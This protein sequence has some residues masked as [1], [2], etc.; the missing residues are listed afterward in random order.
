M[1]AS[2]IIQRVLRLISNGSWPNSPDFGVHL[3][4]L[5]ELNYWVIL[6]H[7]SELEMIGNLQRIPVEIIYII[8]FSNRS[9]KKG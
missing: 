8:R 2:N 5:Q 3:Q 6:M 4:Q 1:Y 9:A 7:K